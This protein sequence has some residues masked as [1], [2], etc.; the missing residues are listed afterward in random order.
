MFTVTTVLSQ[1]R[2]KIVTDLGSGRGVGGWG[3]YADTKPIAMFLHDGVTQV[4]VNLVNS[5]CVHACMCAWG[6]GCMCVCGG[7]CA[8]G[9][10]GVCVCGGGGCMGACI[11][12]YIIIIIMKGAG[13]AQWLERRTRD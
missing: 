13:I 9:G 1:S 4:T 5:M 6:G 8:W 12:E 11:K 7:V 3:V 2:K 10:G